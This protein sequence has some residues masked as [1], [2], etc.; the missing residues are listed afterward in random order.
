M[1]LNKHIHDEDYNFSI[2]LMVPLL[3]ILVCTICLCATTWAWYTASV[4]TGVTSITAKANVS[5]NILTNAENCNVEGENGTYTITNNSDSDAEFEIVFSPSNAANGYYA[6]IEIHDVS[7]TSFLNLFATRVYAEENAQKGY[8]FFINRSNESLTDIT[9]KFKLAP[10]LQ[11]QISINYIWGELDLGGNI[12][13]PGDVNL[14]EEMPTN[15]LIKTDSTVV[16]ETKQYSL[17]SLEQGNEI[18]TYKYS[19]RFVDNNTYEE[20]RPEISEE[21][22]YETVQVS[23]YQMEGYEVLFDSYEDIDEDGIYFYIDTEKE[24]NTFVILYEKIRDSDGEQ[25]ENNQSDMQVEAG[26]TPAD[27]NSNNQ[28]VDYSVEDSEMQSD[29]PKEDEFQRTD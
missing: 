6:E 14:Y 10:R 17:N 9:F 21:T 20:L 24:I 18:P 22:I 26:E 13:Y 4:S 7:N 3:S 29:K 11:K 27:I 8:Y 1:K 15:P 23:D 12:K 5:E 16:D 25:I 2:K 28:P 19:I